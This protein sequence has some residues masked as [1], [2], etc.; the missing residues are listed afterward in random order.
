MNQLNNGENKWLKNTS[1]EEFDTRRIKGSV[2]ENYSNSCHLEQEDPLQEE[3]QMIRE[4]YLKKSKLA[5]AG[6][7]ETQS[8]PTLETLIILPYITGLTISVYSGK[9]FKPVDNQTRDGWT[10]S[11]RVY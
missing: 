1:I 3:L 2:I 9:E 7:T 11:W 8:K 5:K 6:K 10:L 4:N